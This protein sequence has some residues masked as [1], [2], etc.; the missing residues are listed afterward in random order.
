MFVTACESAKSQNI[1]AGEESYTF[2]C[3]TIKE[4]DVVE[5]FGGGG[6]KSE[7]LFSPAGHRIIQLFQA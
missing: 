4:V 3:K 2:C 7:L 1:P 5:F 6:K